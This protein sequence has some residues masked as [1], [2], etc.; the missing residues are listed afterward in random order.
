MQIFL[1]LGKRTSKGRRL[2]S[3]DRQQCRWGMLCC[4]RSSCT[5]RRHSLCTRQERKSSCL[6]SKYNQSIEGEL[7][8]TADLTVI[9]WRGKFPIH[10]PFLLAEKTHREIQYWLECWLWPQ[11]RR[12]SETNS[13][14][15]HAVL[16]YM[17][18]S[19]FLFKVAITSVLRG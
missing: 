12:Q 1:F 15:G 7:M 5:W 4:C 17:C 2:L 6:Y 14:P 19:C 18:C 3:T 13:D 16:Q 8:Y 10:F 11:W 9:N